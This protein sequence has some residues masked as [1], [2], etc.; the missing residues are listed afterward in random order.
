MSEEN[1][2]PQ[3]SFWEKVRKA[4][5]K[6]EKAKRAIIPE[7]EI[8]I[9]WRKVIPLAI[10]VIALIGSAYAAAQIISNW[11]TVGQVSIKPGYQVSAAVIQSLPA[12]MAL[13][14][15]KLFKVQL[16]NN[17]QVQH[18]VNLDLNMSLIAGTGIDSADAI[19]SCN[20]TSPT[21]VR[22]EATFVIL[23]FP[24]NT[25]LSPGEQTTYICKVKFVGED[26]VDKMVKIEA[27]ASEGT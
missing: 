2:A 18:L 20:G 19:I 8:T 22:D 16:T 9:D 14:E 15:E 5:E 17:D 4:A 11:V 6:L 10:A 12:E 27:A 3:L 25:A 21:V 24:T 7:K 1:Q 13:Y 23:R 26:L